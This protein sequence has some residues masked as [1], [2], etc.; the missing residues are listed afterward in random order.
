MKVYGNDEKESAGKRVHKRPEAYIYYIMEKNSKGMFKYYA[1]LQKDIFCP[2]SKFSTKN[3][4][5]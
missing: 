5:T 4:R 1:E 3:V 2:V